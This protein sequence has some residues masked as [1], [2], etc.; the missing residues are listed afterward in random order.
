[1]A[2][3]VKVAGLSAEVTAQA[4]DR[5]EQALAEAD[6]SARIGATADASTCAA[7]VATYRGRVDAAA[8]AW[9]QI[10]SGATHIRAEVMADL[11]ISARAG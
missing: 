9:A 11:L 6:L 10:A 1:V 4:S 8:R 5:M 2:A 3:L 7:A